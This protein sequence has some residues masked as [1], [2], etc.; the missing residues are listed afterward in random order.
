MKFTIDQISILNSMTG[1]GI[2]IGGKT[3]G[4]AVITQLTKEKNVSYRDLALEGL[5]LG[6]GIVKNE[7][8]EEIIKLHE[9]N[10]EESQNY[11]LFYRDEKKEDGSQG[12]CHTILNTVELVKLFGLSEKDAEMMNNYL[13]ALANQKNLRL[14]TYTDLISGKPGIFFVN[15]FDREINDKIL[16]N[17]PEGAKESYLNMLGNFDFK[18]E[19]QTHSFIKTFMMSVTQSC[20]NRYNAVNRRDVLMEV[21]DKLSKI[22]YWNDV[23]VL[24]T[25]TLKD[26]EGFFD[27]IRCFMRV[28]VKN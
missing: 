10:L 21:A 25:P 18:T 23:G 9:D 22:T 12:D 15:Q 8:D 17:D 7:N 28:E 20:Q 3:I 13:G 16:L 11:V 24:S 5:C 2:I 4:C 27:A 6:Y 26:V 14:E 1:E 19:I